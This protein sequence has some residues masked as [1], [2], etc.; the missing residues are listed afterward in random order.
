MQISEFIADL[1][2]GAQSRIWKT[3]FFYAKDM[4][5]RYLRAAI[6]NLPRQI[7]VPFDECDPWRAWVQQKYN[8]ID[9][10]AMS[11]LGHKQ[12]FA[13]QNVTSALP[14]KADMCGARGMSA[15]GQ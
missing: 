9:Y 1:R 6:E 12:T 11:A 2:M 14:P 8:L 7:A 3:F 13:P 5:K 15:K 4:L 10:R